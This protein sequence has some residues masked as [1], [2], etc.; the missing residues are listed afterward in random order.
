MKVPAV[1][2]TGP[3]PVADTTVGCDAKVPEPGLTICTSHDPAPVAMAG[4]ITKLQVYWFEPVSVHDFDAEAA[5]AGVVCNR[6]STP[7][8]PTTTICT[9]SRFEI[10]VVKRTGHVLTSRGRASGGS[11]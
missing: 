10:K 2:L 6:A 8:S 7:K 1:M 4:V 11:A 9:K 5:L 3:Q